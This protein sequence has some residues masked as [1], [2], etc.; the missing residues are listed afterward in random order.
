MPAKKTW[1][2]LAILFFIAVLIKC[3]SF[4]HGWVENYYTA[5]FYPVIAGALRVITGWLPV[6]IGDIFSMPLQQYG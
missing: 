6:S 2:K 3:I 5:M 1:I 4:F